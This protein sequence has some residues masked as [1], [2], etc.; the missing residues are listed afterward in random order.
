[1]SYSDYTRYEAMTEAPHP[2]CASQ[3]EAGHDGTLA[4]RDS[5]GHGLNLR[6][7]ITGAPA[8]EHKIA[9]ANIDKTAAKSD[10]I[11]ARLDQMTIMAPVASLQIPA[12]EGEVV[13]SA[14]PLL[15]WHRRQHE[16]AT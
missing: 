4:L 3:S 10:T 8:E 7:V 12:E 13:A 2:R 14:V 6:A 1:V 5:E 9:E 11:R 16:L 15:D